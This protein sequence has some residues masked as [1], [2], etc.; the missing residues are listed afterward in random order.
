MSRYF[1]DGR[2]I[3]GYSGEGG[4]RQDVR[5]C[6]H[7]EGKMTNKRRATRRLSVRLSEHDLNTIKY[8]AA[9]EGA[10]VSR[11]IVS[12][13]IGRGIK[14]PNAAILDKMATISKL[15]GDLRTAAFPIVNLKEIERI[16]N[17]FR[18]LQEE[19]IS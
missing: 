18:L 2:G 4:P 3:T 5:R 6:T 12:C 1:V 19:V 13:A 9:M 7:F 14:G 10:S 8:R 15:C 16:M 17:K 11:Y